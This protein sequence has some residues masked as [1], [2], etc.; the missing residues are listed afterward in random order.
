MRKQ[1]ESMSVCVD[2]CVCVCAHRW[3]PHQ[4]ADFDKI[5]YVGVFRKYLHGTL[6]F[7][8]ILIPPPFT[9]NPLK[10]QVHFCVILTCYQFGCSAPTHD[11][12]IWGSFHFLLTLYIHRCSLH[13][14]PS[15]CPHGM[16]SD[17]R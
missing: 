10:I 5:R 4:W 13:F 15:I 12:V 16:F 2:V 14:K 17:R 9:I 7:L 6:Y 1:R 11:K 8:K 3:R